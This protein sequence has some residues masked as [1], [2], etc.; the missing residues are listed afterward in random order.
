MTKTQSNI[1]TAQQH[2]CAKRVPVETEILIDVRHLYHG[3]TI[4]LG[5]EI[6]GLISSGVEFL[7]E[8]KWWP[9]LIWIALPIFYWVWQIWNRLVTIKVVADCTFERD[10]LS[11]GF[12]KNCLSWWLIHGDLNMK[13]TK[14]SL[15]VLALI[16][17]R[18]CD[19]I[20]VGS[21][22]PY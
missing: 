19:E 20:E 16:P 4:G 14:F 18:E 6:L 11:W 12:C 17:Q 1:V 5:T 8:R 13:G 15:D 9:K 7:W 22:H 10:W 3:Y 2:N 21:H